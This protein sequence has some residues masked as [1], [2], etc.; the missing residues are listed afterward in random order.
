[1]PRLYECAPPTELRG[2]LKIVLLRYPVTGICCSRC[3]DVCL[4]RVGVRPKTLVLLVWR[5]CLFVAVT[6]ILLYDEIVVDCDKCLM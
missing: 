4:A 6:S 2:D 3:D 5:C 1:M